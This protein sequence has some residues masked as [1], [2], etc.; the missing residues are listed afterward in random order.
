MAVSQAQPAACSVK[1]YWNSHAIRYRPVCGCFHGTAAGFSNCGGT[2]CMARKAK[3]LLPGSLWKVFP[4][5]PRRGAPS[6]RRA[7]ALAPSP[8]F[9]PPP[10]ITDQLGHSCFPLGES[11]LSAAPHRSISACVV[12]SDNVTSPYWAISRTFSAVQSLGTFPPQPN[13][14]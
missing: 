8:P 4:P 11:F 10:R 5:L 6:S 2:A 14:T 1:F 9:S 3:N 7:E 13:I 12:V